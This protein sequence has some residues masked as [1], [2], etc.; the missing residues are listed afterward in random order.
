MMDERLPP[1]RGWETE[2][3]RGRVGDLGVK[4]TEVSA[5]PSERAE[6]RAALAQ[7]HY[8][9]WRRPVGEYL[10]YT[11]RR[12]DCRLLAMLVFGAAAWK[13][14]ARDQW[15]GWTAQQRQARLGWIANSHRSPN[16][17]AVNVR[18]LPSHVLGK[19]P[20]RIAADWQRK[21]AHPLVL[22]ET[23]VE[24]ERFAGTCYRAANRQGLGSTSGRSRQDR[25]RTLQV[26]V[27][28]VCAYALRSDFREV[29]GA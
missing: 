3:V 9:G 4:I 16:L 29:L 6:V 19:V 11:V 15:I 23:F 5:I 8:L 24:R 26:P 1:P 20:G 28:A 17:P 21:Y 18:Y 10:Q 7:F 25:T 27:K 14:A 13:C 2:T 22:V 12:E